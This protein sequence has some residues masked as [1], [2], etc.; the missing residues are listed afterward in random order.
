MNRVIAATTLP[1]YDG[2]ADG[3]VTV[4]SLETLIANGVQAVLALAGVGLFFMLVSAGFN[5]LTAAGDPKKLDQA[6]ST[7]TQ[8]IIGLVVIVGALLIM[9]IIEAFLGLNQGTLTEFEI[10]T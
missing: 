9:R 6:R 2:S 10:P 3:V 7:M 5:Y 8:A 4:K 1:T